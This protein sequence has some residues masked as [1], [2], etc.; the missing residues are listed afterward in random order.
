MIG[1][2]LSSI[3]YNSHRSFDLFYLFLKYIFFI[4][5]FLSAVLQSP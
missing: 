5:G 2:D 4:Y 1:V 3:D